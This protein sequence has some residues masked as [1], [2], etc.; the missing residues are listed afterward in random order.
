MGNGTYFTTYYSDRTTLLPVMWRF[1]DGAE[2]HIMSFEP[3]IE[4]NLIHIPIDCPQRDKEDDATRAAPHF[5]VLP[6]V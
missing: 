4:S 2:F 1:F 6:L 3:G 5:R